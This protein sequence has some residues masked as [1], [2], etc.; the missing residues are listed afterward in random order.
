[1]VWLIW[2]SRR[3]FL[4]AIAPAIALV[5]LDA[6]VCV[7]QRFFEAV[8]Y[9]D[10]YVDRAKDASVFKACSYKAIQQLAMVLTL[11]S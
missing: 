1:M 10:A 7:V 3:H 4:V 9:K 2:I 11:L 8:V 5:V 6:G